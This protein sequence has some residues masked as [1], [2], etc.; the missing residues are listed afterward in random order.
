MAGSGTTL[1]P[2][3]IAGRKA[4]A[5]EV[6]AKFDWI[7][8]NILPML[9]GSTTDLAYDLGTSTARWNFGNID[10]IMC[11]SINPTST[12]KCVVIGTTT[13]ATA[14]ANNSD[15][16]LEIAGNRAILFPR[17]TT[18]QRNAL[19]AINGMQVYD[20]TLNAFKI[21]QNGAWISSGGG[22]KSIQNTSTSFNVNNPGLTAFSTST[23]VGITAITLANAYVIPN[24]FRITGGDAAGAKP[25]S[26]NLDLSTTSVRVTFSGVGAANYSISVDCPFTVI[27][28]P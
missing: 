13:A 16:A 5:S 3:L 2:S 9:S 25:I 18:T 24:G 20:S 8:A 4:K 28:F 26:Y 15:V 1:W 6:E 23:V 10:K 14:A 27:E 17:L 11:Q 22:V 19:A 12:A 21:Y 7:E